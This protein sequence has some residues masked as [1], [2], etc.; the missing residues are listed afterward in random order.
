M[1]LDASAVLAYLLEETGADSVRE[2][3][4]ADSA[5]STINFA[6]VVTRY[7][8]GGASD[9]AVG[10]LRD[11]LPIRFVPFDEATAIEAGR[12][13]RITAAFGLSLGDRGC[14]ATARLGGYAILTAD[15]IWK[16]VAPLV[17]VDVRLIR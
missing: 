14:I 13:A 6:E 4:L 12:L 9:D 5:M 1:L 15:R 10:R 11:R 8:R 7:V 17:G 2:T 16:E 3:L